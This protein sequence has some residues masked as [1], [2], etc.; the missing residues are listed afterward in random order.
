[1]K[2]SY[3]DCKSQS[4]IIY[5]LGFT[6]VYIS[7]RIVILTLRILIF[8]INESILLFRYSELVHSKYVVT[9]PVAY[10]LEYNPQCQLSIIRWLVILLSL[11]ITK[12]NMNNRAYI[13]YVCTA[14]HRIGY[15][16]SIPL[17]GFWLFRNWLFFSWQISS[18]PWPCT[19]NTYRG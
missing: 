18:R 11:I 3:C 7:K 6:I 4:K 5:R 13:M 2:T 17:Q 16:Y 10:V 8:C 14:W 1:M 19:S 9:I 12:Q 15:C